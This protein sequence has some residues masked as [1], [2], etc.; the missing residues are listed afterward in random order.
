MSLAKLFLISKFKQNTKKN[1]NLPLVGFPRGNK[2]ELMF[3]R[4]KLSPT[5]VELFAAPVAAWLS[6]LTQNPRGSISA[7]GWSIARSK[8]LD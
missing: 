8:G 2:Y 5:M 4:P 1:N 7:M 3:P 6:R